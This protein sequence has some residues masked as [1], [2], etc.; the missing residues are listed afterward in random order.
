MKIGILAGPTASGKSALALEFARSHPKIELINADSLIIYR[1]MDI[2]TAKP[3]PRELAEIRHHLVNIREPDEAFTAGDFV[4]AAWDAIA[5]IQTRGRAPLLV[6]GSGFYLKALLHGL[7]PAHPSDPDLRARFEARTS[8]SLF[9]ELLR[10]DPEAARKIGVNDR[11]RLVRAL[12]VFALSGATPSGLSRAQAE[13]GADP[14]FAFWVIDRENEE[15]RNRIQAR[16]RQMLEAGLIEEVRALATRYPGVRP[17][18][19]VGYAQ[20]SSHLAGRKPSG[21]EP[22]PGLAGLA[23]EIELA[24]LQLV[25]RQ[26]TWF[27]SQKAAEFFVLDRDLIRIK[28]RLERNYA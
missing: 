5:D 13:R 18:S 11:Y 25:K 27:R 21:R 23:D 15:L 6:G 16:T 17:L 22:R 2:G 20:V 19:A 9:E 4:R 26:R 3:T 24:T 8:Q 10:A 14:R 7:W 12:E 1:A 28:E